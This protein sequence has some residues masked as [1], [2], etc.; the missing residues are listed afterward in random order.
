MAVAGQLY[1][2]LTQSEGAGQEK[3]EA[4]LNSYGEKITIQVDQ[5]GSAS[6]M[7]SGRTL[8]R[9]LDSTPIDPRFVLLISNFL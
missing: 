9:L 4:D 5:D 3:P 6:N 7:C 1:F 2:L 8:V